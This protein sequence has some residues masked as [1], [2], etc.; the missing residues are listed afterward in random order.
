MERTVAVIVVVLCALGCATAQSYL[1]T[2]LPDTCGQTNFTGTPANWTVGGFFTVVWTTNGQTDD[3][4][5]LYL[6]HMNGTRMTTGLGT[7]PTLDDV[8]TRIRVPPGLAEGEYWLEW[9]YR[10]VTNC[11]YVYLNP[12]PLGSV[13]LYAGQPVTK[14]LTTQYDFYELNITG[15]NFL[16][17][18]LT[19]ADGVT[20]PNAHANIVIKE[21]LLAPYPSLT[22][23]DEISSTASTGTVGLGACNN[24]GA[25]TGF[26]IVVVGASGADNSTQYT[27]TATTYDGLVNVGTPLRSNAHAGNRY[28]RTQAYE[29]FEH[30]RRVVLQ[31]DEEFPEGVVFQL[32]ATCDFDTGAIIGEQTGGSTHCIQ[33]GEQQGNK[34]LMVPTMT[35]AYSISAEDGLCSDT[36]AGVALVVSMTTLLSVFAFLFLM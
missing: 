13:L 22:V 30:P 35:S 5:T 26:R 10:S 24:R 12:D 21:G 31:G 7:N 25:S 9:R 20:Y 33:L 14:P 6:Y 16:W 4:V 34:Y 32:S 15:R 1:V 18:E 2:P 17:V 8:S 29:T 11:A 28:F 19:A 27:V 23:Y 36:G 3:T